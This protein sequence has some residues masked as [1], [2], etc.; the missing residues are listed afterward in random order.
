MRVLVTGGAGFIGSNF[1][2][3]ALSDQFPEITEVKVIDKLSYAG[4]LSNLGSAL[5]HSNF[6]FIHGDICDPK[7]VG[8]LVSEVDAVINFAAESHVDRSIL[9][10]GPFVKTNVLG[11]QVLLDDIKPF[12]KKRFIQISTDEVYGSISKGSWDEE[13]PLQPNSPYAASKASA[14]LLIRSYFI[15][16]GLNTSITRCSN[17]FGPNQDSE[18]LIPNVISKLGKG[19]KVSLYG[20]GMNVRDWLYVDDHCK[21]I[22]LV[23]INGGPGEIYNIGGGTELTNLEL[24]RKLLK[25]MNKSED[26]IDFVEDRLGH[27]LR[28]SVNY[29]KIQK[30]GYSP[31]SDFDHH[32]SQTVRQY[33]EVF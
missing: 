9:N 6:E 23:L 24:T 29:K 2:N 27:D 28:Y 11:T 3:M 1:V 13:H 32:L 7:I 33:L 31:S 5:E 19:E 8:M 16:H 25:L 22:Y 20:D 17:N 10:S 18:K 14:D 26:S 15:T 4:K 12:K 30:L 21:G